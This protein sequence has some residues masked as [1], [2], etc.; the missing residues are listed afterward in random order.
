MIGSGV[1]S[2]EGCD[3]S[4]CQVVECRSGCDEGR[5]CLM[6]TRRCPQSSGP[7]RG[8]ESSGALRGAS[9]LGFWRTHSVIFLQGPLLGS[10]DQ[11]EHCLL[12]SE[13]STYYLCSS[14]FPE[15]QELQFLKEP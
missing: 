4:M 11:S 5:Q 6:R 7:W 15:L 10:G 1:H 13:K 14:A 8:R 3:S 2:G 12:L 9:E